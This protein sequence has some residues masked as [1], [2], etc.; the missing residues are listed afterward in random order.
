VT[1]QQ[2]NATRFESLH[3]GP[4]AFVIANAWDRGSARVLAGLGASAIATTSAGLARS[5]GDTDYTAGRQAVLEHCASLCAAVAV[6]VSADLENGFGDDP[7]TCAETI[8]LAAATGLCGG[9]IEDASG[10]PSQPIYPLEFAVERV[11]AAAA[12]ARAA[13]HRFLLTARAENY[14]HGRPDLADTIARLQA[15]QDAGADVLFAPGL[16]TA[17]DIRTVCASVDRPVNVLRSP[18][19]AAATVEELGALGVRRIS[20]GALFHSAAMSG[21]VDAAREVLETGGFGFSSAL[22]PGAEID[23]LLKS[24]AG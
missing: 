24:G 8:R 6:P 16:S 12:A 10:D 13:P 20:V 18:N 1:S 5:L 17:E 4:G 21:L 9:S 19:V 23:R 11:R 3:K 15:F 7:G 14:L 22:T 2:Q